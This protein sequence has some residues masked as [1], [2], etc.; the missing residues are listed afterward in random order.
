MKL[1]YWPK[2]KAKPLV[3]DVR[4]DIALETVFQDTD[5]WEGVRLVSINAPMQDPCLSFDP[6]I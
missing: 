2:P 1:Y 3:Y 4:E 5:K 6:C